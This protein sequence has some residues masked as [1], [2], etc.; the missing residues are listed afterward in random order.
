MSRRTKLAAPQ[1]MMAPLIDIVF[2]LLIFFMLVTKFLTPS[3]NVDLPK[4]VS[5][6]IREERAIHLGIDK[7]LNLFIGEEKADWATLVE[8]LNAVRERENPQ[9]VRIK[10]DKTV[11]IEYV[12]RAIDA[13]RE[14]GMK[15]VALE[16]ETPRPES[17]AT[18]AT[19]IDGDPSQ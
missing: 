8:S 7:D 17:G 6:D 16:A 19:A 3:I 1:V 15:T 14:A 2:L 9:I 4:S 18:A 12:V 11:P 13:V 5:A 10:A